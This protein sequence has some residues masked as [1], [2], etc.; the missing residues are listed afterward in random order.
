M[1]TVSG[2]HPVGLLMASL[3]EING[4]TVIIFV[5]ESLQ[6]FAEM[7]IN[8]TWYE[9]SVEVVLLKTCCGFFSTDDEPSLKSQLKFV[10]TAAGLERLLKS[11][12]NGLQPA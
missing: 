4:K 1:V 5:T 12:V 11:T 8:L 10:A 2:E 3:A 6:L 9:T 7:A